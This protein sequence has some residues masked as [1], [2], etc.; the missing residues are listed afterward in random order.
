MYNKDASKLLRSFLNLKCPSFKLVVKHVLLVLIFLNNAK[1][2]S[3][4]LTDL[5]GYELLRIRQLENNA[6]LNLSFI[7][8]PLDQAHIS[9]SIV[10]DSSSRSKQEFEIRILP[11]ILLNQVNSRAPYNTNDGLM[12]PAKGYQLYASGGVFMKFK[13]FSIQLKP[14]MVYAANPNFLNSRDQIAAD[15]YTDYLSADYGADIPVYYGGKDFTTLSF[16]QSN[17]K[18]T[19]GPVSVG[20]SNENL[21]WGPGRRNALI[22]GN[23]ARGFKHIS[24]NTDKP[25]ITPIGLFEGQIIS[26]RLENSKSAYNSSLVQ[27]WR[28]LSG[29]V[30]SY[31]P[32]WIP[33]LFVGLTR[34]FQIYNTDVKGIGDYFPLLQP[35]EKLKTNEGGRNRDQVSSIFG[36]LVFP[37]SHS[38]IYFEYGRNDHSVDIRDF[39]MEPDHSRAYIFGGQKLVDLNKN[40]EK[41]LFSAELTQLSQSPSRF[42]REAGTWYVHSI[43]QGYT[44]KGEVIGSSSGP[45]GN[46][47]TLEISLL[48]RF[49]KYGLIFERYIHNDDYYRTIN[50]GARNFNGQWVDLSAGLIYNKRYKNLSVHSKFIAIK[51]FNYLWQSGVGTV[52]QQNPFNVHGQLGFSYNFNK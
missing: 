13:I 8:R 6:G 28:Y 4:P 22:M 7:I 14:E 36:R 25:V 29:M 34:V 24:L 38:E 48:N 20:L 19:L 21:W 5:S 35:F 9:D 15:K 12:I 43:K 32:R 50:M 49:R 52:P 42:V 18:L 3:L 11:L 45:G 51:S 40:Q 33:G 47:Q 10:K 41:L 44:N 16:G 27:D 1:A 26:G 17:V 2:Q 30:L 39:T 23:S 46:M 37:E 31:H